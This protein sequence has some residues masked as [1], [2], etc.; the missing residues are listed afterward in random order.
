MS[1][2][3]INECKERMQKTLESLNKEL[4]GLRSGRAN[5][6]LVADIKV[7]YYGTPTPLKQLANI[8][9]PEAKLLV[10]QPYDKTSLGEIEK[11]IQSADIGINP[12]ND[13]NFIRLPIPPLTEDT[14]RDLVKQAKKMGEEKKIALRNVRRDSNDKVKEA[15]KNKEITKDEQKKTLD[16]IQEVTGD[17]VKRIDNMI[18]KKE[19]EILSV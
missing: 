1:D 19:Q 8:S 15:E 14:R 17:F 10:I 5:A 9:I 18:Q 11:A 4:M 16:D 13:G 7:N 2:L 6:S 12:N 3:I